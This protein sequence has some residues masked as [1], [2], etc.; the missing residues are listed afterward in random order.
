MTKEEL[1]EYIDY[2]G[3]QDIRDFTKLCIEVFGKPDGVLIKHGENVIW[4]PSKCTVS[5]QIHTAKG[6][7]KRYST[8][9]KVGS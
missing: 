9:L 3:L 8:R 7:P 6:Q 1:N 4:P 5:F 2:H